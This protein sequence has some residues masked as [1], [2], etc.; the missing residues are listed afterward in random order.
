[1]CLFLNSKLTFKND[2]CSFSSFI[3]G[4]RDTQRHFKK[5]MFN[6]FILVLA[7]PKDFDMLLI[8]EENKRE[9]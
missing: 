2:Q 6:V 8:K 1:M 3:W 4:L 9:Q 5:L 7:F